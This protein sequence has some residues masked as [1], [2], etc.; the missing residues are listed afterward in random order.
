MLKGDAEIKTVIV[1]CVWERTCKEVL[2]YAVCLHSN[3]PF[4]NPGPYLTY[5]IEM[6]AV[7]LFSCQAECAKELSFQVG[8]VL[9]DGKYAGATVY[10]L[11]TRLLDND[12]L[13]KLDLSGNFL[14]KRQYLS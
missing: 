10:T 14:G 6:R 7:A 3:K 2:T 12:T 1:I 11:L 8:D 4:L 9:E 13:A 5:L